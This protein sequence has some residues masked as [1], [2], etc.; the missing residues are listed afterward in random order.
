[1]LNF[2]PHRGEVEVEAGMEWLEL[3][4]TLLNIQKGREPQWGIIQKQAGADRLSIGAALA[5]NG[6]GR[7]LH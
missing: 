2:D 6:H 7:G 1:M 4:N 5:A 3:V